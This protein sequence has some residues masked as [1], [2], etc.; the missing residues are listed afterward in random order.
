MGPD[1]LQP[2][3]GLTTSLPL[4]RFDRNGAR[5]ITLPLLRQIRHQIVRRM[6]R[7]GARQ[8]LVCG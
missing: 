5:A 6:H 4:S 1:R 8:G 2:T 3:G 7:E